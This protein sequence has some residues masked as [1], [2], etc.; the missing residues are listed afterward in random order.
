MH[1][2]PSDSTP[3]EREAKPNDRDR[4]RTR[5]APAVL[6]SRQTDNPPERRQS[7]SLTA[8]GVHHTFTGLDLYLESCGQTSV[9]TIGRHEPVHYRE[10]H[11]SDIPRQKRCSVPTTQRRRQKTT[12]EE[13]GD[14]SRG[15]PCYRTQTLAAA[16]EADS[17]SR[18]T[19]D[20]RWSVSE[21]RA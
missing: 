13:D 10:D 4:W 11:R 20:L 6:W 21:S 17:E 9:Y 5:A 16:A 1:P 3:G 15:S 19:R 12:A 2:R 8:S 7:E 18:S 14:R